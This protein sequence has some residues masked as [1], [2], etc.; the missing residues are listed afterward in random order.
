MQ[1]TVYLDNAATTPLDPRVADA[2]A[3]ALRAPRA[4][5]S[6]QHSP[7]AAARR[8]VEAARE[9][10]ASLIGAS[11]QEIHFTSG[12]TEADALAVLGLARAAARE[13]GARHVVVSAVEH[14]AVREA[15]S[16]LESE[17]F[18]VT[19]LPVDREGLVDPAGLE[20]ALRNDTA[21]A[22]AMWANNEVG[23]V[24]PVAELARICRERGVPFHCD[25]V[26][27]AGHVPV[28]VSETP[29]S[30]LAFT[31][32]KL[33]GPSGVGALYVREGVEVEPLLRGG[34]Q[35]RGLRSGTENV[36]GLHAFGEACRIARGELDERAAHERELRDRVISAAKELGGV[37]LNGHPER[38]LPGNVHLSVEG[39]DA[40]SLV[41][42]CDALGY[43][44]GNGAA[45][46]S[47]EHKASQ[48]LLAM[49][50]TEAEAFSSV[51]VSAGKD[52]TA[53]EIEGFLGAFST[54]VGRLRELSPLYAG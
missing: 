27:A 34:G 33:H 17:G 11:P 7:G 19:R 53:E 13:R 25:A 32:H 50:L 35:E 43:A 31:G 23:T 20:A 22:A 28:D 51:R 44:I 30:T 52:N 8:A 1:R 54:A 40:E 45:C 36:A 29:V 9:E 41:M 48:V 2:F 49:G 3:D 6:S 42:M 12:G 16:Q 37:T 5:P 4:N 10:A 14:P 24:Q 38:R 39:A 21:L 15:A 47:S 46:S 18:E 26:Q